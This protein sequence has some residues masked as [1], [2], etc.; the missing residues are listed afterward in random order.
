MFVCVLCVAFSF[1]LFIDSLVGLRLTLQV[2]LSIGKTMGILFDREGW[3][4]HIM[5]NYFSHAKG[6]YYGPFL[7]L[8]YAG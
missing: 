4:L 8:S 5:Y 2:F 1:V 7:S 3:D 6:E